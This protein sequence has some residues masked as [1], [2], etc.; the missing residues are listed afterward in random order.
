MKIPIIRIAYRT[1]VLFLEALRWLYA[2]CIARPVLRSIAT[3]GSGL[4][5]ERIPYMRGPGRL[6]L[7]QKVRIS[8]K[9]GIAFSRHGSAPELCLGSRVFVGHQ[10]SFAIADRICIGDDCLLAHGV[11]IA[12]HDGHPL[13]PY[14]RL[15]RAPVALKDVH[16]VEIGNNVWIGARSRILKGVRI[17]DNV[18]IGAE[19]VVTKD[20]E[21]DCLAVGNPARVIRKLTG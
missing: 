13:D 5:V 17:G 21:A 20:V 19:S 8:G 18:V 12:D 15:R 14:S 10:C 16:P 4:F 9:I 11:H 3:G 1:G 7:G 6:C 2:Q